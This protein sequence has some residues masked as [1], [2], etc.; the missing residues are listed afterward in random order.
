MLHVASHDAYLLSS[1]P[2][3]RS[4]EQ[5]R[6]RVEELILERQL[7]EVRDARVHGFGA[8]EGGDRAPV[9]AVRF[10]RLE[11]AERVGRGPVGVGG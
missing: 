5:L 11:Q 6:L 3:G 8:D 10:E 7:Q 9:F 1:E 4:A 2:G